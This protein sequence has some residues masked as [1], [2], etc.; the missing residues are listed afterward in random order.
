MG[1]AD[2]AM[3]EGPLDPGIAVCGGVLTI[4]FGQRFPGV[5]AA[6]PATNTL[7]ALCE[8]SIHTVIPTSPGS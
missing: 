3:A 6:R 7:D 1:G 8:R 4:Q 2:E 5:A